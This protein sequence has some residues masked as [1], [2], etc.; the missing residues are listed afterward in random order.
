MNTP[1]SPQNRT[2]SAHKGFTLIELLTV[3][4]IIGI[5]AAIIIP[6][7][8]A[9]RKSAQSSQSMSNLRQIGQAMMVHASDNKD[10]LVGG[11]NI[12]DGQGYVSWH[13]VIYNYV[14]LQGKATEARSS[15]VYICGIAQSLLPFGEAVNDANKL[16]FTANGAYLTD[17]A[18]DPSNNGF[19]SNDPPDKLGSIRTPSQAVLVFDGISINNPDPGIGVAS[20]FLNS[21]FTSGRIPDRA[22]NAALTNKLITNTNEAGFAFRHGGG[23]KMHAVMAD[24]SV[25]SFKVGELLNRHIQRQR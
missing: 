1:H 14:G 9:V 2:T 24:N 15:A 5:L 8:G 17:N 10:R 19:S 16:N 6:T 7:V 25:R 20:P 11:W 23:T 21:D 22:V 3:I 13:R 12:V 18:F 4:A